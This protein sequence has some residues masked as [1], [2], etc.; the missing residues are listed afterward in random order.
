MR[1]ALENDQF[2]LYCQPILT[3]ETNE[4]SQYGL[5]LRL[6]DVKGCEQLRPNA[7]LYIAERF[8]LIPPI[9]LWVVR[10]AIAR[11]AAYK[12]TGQRLALHV[13]LSGRSVGDPTLAGL[14]ENALA[15][16]GIDPR[17]SGL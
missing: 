6:P 15:E 8:G 10:K 12:R 11:I 2:V 9:D 7:F 3:L 13:N 17:V 5:L 4:V 1:R 16:G 14:I